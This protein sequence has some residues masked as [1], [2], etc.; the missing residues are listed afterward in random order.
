MATLSVPSTSK[1]IFLVHRLSGVSDVKLAQSESKEASLKLSDG[2]TVSGV[3]TISEYLISSAK[4]SHIRDLVG[5]S[6]E[7]K[8]EVHQWVNFAVTHIKDMSDEKTLHFA[9]SKIDTHLAKQVFLVSNYITLA[10]ILVFAYLHPYMQKHAKSQDKIMSTPNV[11]RHFD[12]VQH[13]LP[14]AEMIGALVSLNLDGPPRPK[15]AQPKDVKKQK[16]APSAEAS[17]KKTKGEST[18]SKPKAEKPS[19]KSEDAGKSEKKEKR[20]KK[21]KESKEGKENKREKKE[22]PKK[23]EDANDSVDPSRLDLR[24]GLIVNCKK[25][26]A[27]DSLYVEEIDVGEEAPRT[28]VSGLVNHVKLEDMQKRYVVL[29]C[30][31]KPVAMRGVKSHAMVLCTTGADGKV[32]ILAPPK[33]SKPGDRVYFEGYEAGKPDEV[34]NPKKKVWEGIQPCLKTSDNLEATFVNPKDSKVCK[35]MTSKGVIMSATVKGG[36]IK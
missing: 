24:I 4:D 18:P 1:E 12:L 32:E 20:A 3:R 23:K 16:A 13:T 36:S 10:D 6:K 11:V 26:E 5:K 17:P 8:A 28:V 31:L 7:E 30:N 27:A 22:E 14:N 21:E 15:P 19:A 34:L 29:L 25:H 2:S 33:D 35:M 9:L